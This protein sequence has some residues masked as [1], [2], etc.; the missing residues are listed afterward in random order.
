MINEFVITILAIFV[1]SRFKISFMCRIFNTIFQKSHKK[2]R[3]I[4]AFCDKIL[5]EPR[6]LKCI[7]CNETQIICNDHF[8]SNEIKCIKCQK[9]IPNEPQT[10]PDDL[11]QCQIIERQISEDEH[12]TT[13][14]SQ[15]KALMD[16]YLES[17]INYSN[18]LEV[19]ANEFSLKQ[20]EHFFN[21][22]N[23]IDINRETLIEEIYKNES[24]DRQTIL[25]DELHKSSANL[26]EQI[27]KKNDEFTSKFAQ[28]IIR[29]DPLKIVSCLIPRLVRY[30]F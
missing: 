19:K 9:I 26:I 1:F 14:E 5:K 18:E 11:D 3:F 29:S 21:L 27:E 6:T 20:Y 17:I 15:C 16:S 12:L 25:L 30:K 10:F 2:S 23:E 22:K 4:C 7:Q 13:Y 8:H 28:L 24:M